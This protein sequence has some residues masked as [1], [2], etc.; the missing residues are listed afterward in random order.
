MSKE[1]VIVSAV[2]T[3]GDASGIN[4]GAATF[5]IMSNE[6]A[7]ELALTP[8]ATLC[9]GGGQGVATIVKRQ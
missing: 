4:D 1:V 3:A 7:D 9:I 8:L 6:K 2:R 5:V